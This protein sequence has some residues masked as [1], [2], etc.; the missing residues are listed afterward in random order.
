M[1]AWLAP[2]L[3]GLA[4]VGGTLLQNKGQ[5][6]AADRSMAFSER[7]AGTQAQRSAADYAAAGLNPALAY[8]RTAAAPSGVVAGVEDVAEKGVASALAAKRMKAEI[9][10]LEQQAF[11]A[12]AEGQS[13]AVDASIK[14]SH[15]EGEP[16]YRDEAMA[17]RRG[18]IRDQAFESKRQ[19]VQLQYEAARAALEKAMLPGAMNEAELMR[20][21]G[22]FSNILRFIRPR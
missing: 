21:M 12:S 22:I 17:R 2:L 20:R 14:S 19:P 3:T 13:A 8:D 7:M 6:A 9:E 4:S 5:R 16:S 18:V 1:P 15:V 10:L 11:K